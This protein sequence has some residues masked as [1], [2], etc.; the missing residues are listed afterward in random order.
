MKN[1]NYENR[2][3]FISNSSLGRCQYTE[4]FLDGGK[5]KVYV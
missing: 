4:L 2:I 5:K 1:L 3:R